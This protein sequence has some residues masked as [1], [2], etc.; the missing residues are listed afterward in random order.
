MQGMNNVKSECKQ[1]HV[2][3]CL[4][5]V[6]ATFR[7]IMFPIQRDLSDATREVWLFHLLVLGHIYTSVR[8]SAAVFTYLI[9]EIN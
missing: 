8:V 3:C 2:V 6:L 5:R 9:S 7:P 4:G 1:F